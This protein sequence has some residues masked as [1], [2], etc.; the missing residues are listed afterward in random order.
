ML[1][2]GIMQGRLSPPVDGQ[3]QAF[4]SEHWKEEFV[5]AREAGFKCIE[6]IYDKSQSRL[7]PLESENGIKEIQK[8]AE[9]TGV[10][11]SS[12]CADY[13]M[14]DLLVKE[15]GTENQ[16]VVSN[17]KWL[18]SQ[19]NKLDVNHIVLPFVD[20]SSLA[21][22]NHVKTASNIIRFLIPHAVN[23]DIE[24][25]LESDLPPKLF[26]N[27]LEEIDHQFVKV[28]FDIGNSAALGYD[29]TEELRALSPFLGG[30]HVKDRLLGGESVPL[31][32]GNAN[33]KTCFRL[34]KKYDYHGSLI[35]QA[36]RGNVGQEF[37][38]ANKNR[39]L[40]ENYW[41]NIE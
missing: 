24:L 32:T 23:C 12:I 1:P 37:S 33:F 6:W 14:S 8:C 19:S 34:L 15:D 17:L 20:A 21:T 4:P 39:K 25:H 35:L 10:R 18:I 9:Q 11:V 41:H 22:K 27:L 38:L 16:R 26:T 29:P 7:N 30:V 31:G 5:L 36:A 28:N 13:Y 3:I 2:I 40:I